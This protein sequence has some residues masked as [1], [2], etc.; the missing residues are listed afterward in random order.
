MRWVFI[1]REVPLII[2]LA[3]FLTPFI[4]PKFIF[5]HVQT[6]PATLHFKAGPATKWDRALNAAYS[7]I[8]LS[9][10][11][12]HCYKHITCLLLSQL[13][14][15]VIKGKQDWLR[16]KELLESLDWQ[17]NWYVASVASGF[18][19]FLPFRLLAVKSQ[20]LNVKL[21]MPQ[22]A[23]N[24]LKR[25]WLLAA[26]WPLSVVLYKLNFSLRCSLSVH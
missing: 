6:I 15:L 25:F 8:I 9:E 3:N 19:F 13:S 22:P 10:P 2:G 21:E 12:V 14:H 20:I 11:N 4:A 1:L 24:R 17:M 18:F 16:L 26:S 5:L 7:W 23:H